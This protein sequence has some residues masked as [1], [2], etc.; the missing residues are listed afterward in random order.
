[1]DES[2]IA[3]VWTTLKEYL[4][5][6]HFEMAAERYVD[7]MADYGVSDEILK[8]CFGHCVN[9]D[10]A[11]KYYLDIDTGDGYEDEEEWDE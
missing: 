10:N 5:K 7:L 2:Q 3:D 4:D 9:L 1:M 8:D 11:I 6:K